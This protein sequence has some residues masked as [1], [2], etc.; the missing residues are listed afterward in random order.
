MH[1]D[2]DYIVNPANEDLNHIGGL[3]KSIADKAGPDML[4]ECSTFI[5]QYR[6]LNTGNALRTTAGRLPFLGMC[7]IFSS[8]LILGIIHTVGP[9]WTGGFQNERLLLKQ[10]VESTLKIAAKNG[11]ISIAVP[12]ISAGIF[13]YPK[14]ECTLEIVKTVVSF[15]STR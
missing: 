4:S 8:V 7:F 2:V 12:T 1:N 11:A 3:A 14:E 5:T 10:A 15:L 13:G 6:K 9:I